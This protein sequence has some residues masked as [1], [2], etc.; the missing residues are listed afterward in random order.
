MD[1]H[2][3][4]GEL[5]LPFNDAVKYSILGI[6]LTLLL[7]TLCILAWE[8]VRCCKRNTTHTQ[9]EDGECQRLVSNSYADNNKNPLTCS[10][11][12]SEQ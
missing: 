6:S 12:C 10:L 1:V 4:F 3:V 9:P 5:V 2:A 11:S 8:V 7:L